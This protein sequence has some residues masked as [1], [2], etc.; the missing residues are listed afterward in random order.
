M[1]DL[2]SR[3]V[4]PDW[5]E[6]MQWSKARNGQGMKVTLDILG[7]SSRKEN[8]IQDSV[9]EYMSLV[10]TIAAERLDA[11]VTI[12]ITSLGYLLDRDVCL[13]NVLDIGRAANE[14]RIGFEIDMEGRSLVDFSLT[15]ARNCMENGL[16]ATVALQAYLDRTGTDLESM[17]ESGIRVRLVKGA[18]AGDLKE[19]HEI[20]SRFVGLAKVLSESG[21][22]FALGTHDPEI[23]SWIAAELAQTK[24][25]IELGMLKGLSDATKLGFAKRGWK[26]A[27]YVPFGPN[28]T[29]YVHRRVEYLQDLQAQGRSPAP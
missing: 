22:E 16:N 10:Q 1:N 9:N 17:I 26:V 23:I 4:L 18:Y 29:A 21:V 3:W 13:R 27:E 25:K 7:E 19:F 5:H 2:D 12:K 20:Q 15:V 28:A 8:E 11:A 24:G 14:A 6:A